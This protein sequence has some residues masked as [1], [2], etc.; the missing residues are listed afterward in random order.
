MLSKNLIK[1]ACAGAGK[2]W[3]I[4]NTALSIVSESNQK[5]VAI[6][7]YTNRGIQAIK[8]EI[9]KQYCGVLHN[10]ITVDSLY[11]FIFTELIKPYQTYMFGINEVTGFDFSHMYGYINT[12]RMGTKARY[13]TSNGKISA[14]EAAELAIHLN[15]ISDGD[16]IKRLE[17][18]YDTILF[19]EVQD[20][21]GYDLEIIRLIA[22][23]KI[24]LICVGDPKQ[25][26][27]TTNNGTKNKNKSGKNMGVFFKEL[28]KNNLASIN[29]MVASRRFNADICKF[30][31]NIYPSDVTTTTI[32]SISTDHDGVYLILKKDLNKYYDFYSPQI[33]RYDSRTNTLG[34]NAMNYGESKGLTFDR[35]L[36]FPNKP[37]IDF[38]K[39]GK[40][41]SSPEKYYIAVTRPR[42]SIA[43][44]VNS[45]PIDGKFHY[46]DV[47]IPCGDEF[48]NG[49]KIEL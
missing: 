37:L 2:T 16:V 30:A 12:H 42:Y 15:T 13:I 26:T 7:S 1:I 25:A 23:S 21:S 11:S 49:K 28:E 14:N 47:D 43:I 35:I 20:L 9:Q 27:F 36:I 10:R 22:N 33:L 4:C 29:Y 17:K 39:S 41:L 48:I 19:D 18:I 38:I 40:A 6:I 24:K 5:R 32:M 45:F 34:L 8:T 31:N 44:V 3:D 46:I